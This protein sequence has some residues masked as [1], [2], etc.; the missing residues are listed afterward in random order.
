[1]KE[2]LN[3]KELIKIGF[4]NYNTSNS[5]V[6]KSQIIKYK[7]RDKFLYQPCF[8]NKENRLI[9]DRTGYWKIEEAKKS[10]DYYG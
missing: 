7:Y 1:M 8:Y 2:K 3:K 4:E 5:N 10:I 6:I 9:I